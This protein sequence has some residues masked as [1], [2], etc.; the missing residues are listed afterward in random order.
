MPEPLV[1]QED[2]GHVRVLTI[3][4]PSKRNAFDNALYGAMAD[5][6]TSASNDSTVRAVVLRAIRPDGLRV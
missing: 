4:R 2:R 5:A 3:N 1:I 6:I